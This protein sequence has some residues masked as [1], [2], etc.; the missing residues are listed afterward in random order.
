MTREQID[1][2]II[3]G[4]QAGLAMSYY[5]GQCGRE[6]VIL[7]RRRIAERWRSE[8]WDSLTF[9]F[10]NWTMQ[11]PGYPYQGTDPEGFAHRDEVVRFIESYATFIKAPVRCGVSVVSL[12]MEQGFAGF[13]I[14]T[15]QGC[16]KAANVVIATGPYQQPAIPAVGDQIHGALQVHSSRYRNP[17]ELPSGAVLVVGSGASGC[18]ITED[19][20]RRGRRVYLAVGAHRRVPRRYR[21]RDFAFWEFALGEFDRTLDQR[22]AERVS[23]LLTGV[24]GG[25]DIDL[26]HLALEGVVLLGRL[27]AGEQGKLAFS[28]DLQAKLQRGDQWFEQF[29]IAVDAYAQQHGLVL[30]NNDRVHEALPDPREASTPIRELDLKAAGIS[31]IIWATGFRYDFEWIQLPI[32]AYGDE[33][34]RCE[35]VHARGVTRIPGLYLLGLP[36][37]HKRK[38]SLMAGVGEDAAF[39]ANQIT[40][41]N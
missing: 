11:L 16:I 35:P 33:R 26:R 17:E 29:V 22:P 6:H 41:R 15:D 34:L 28:P 30:P 2:V 31:S 7:E 4:G 27:L 19:L 32:F 1:T 37:L 14:E 18:Q 9:Q 20:L 36:W 25:H 38:S 40:S 12:R 23:A 8:R 10:P 13:R 21:G 39:L 5:L 24:G 3:G